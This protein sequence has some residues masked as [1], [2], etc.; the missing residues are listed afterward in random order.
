MTP[1]I[2]NI[3]VLVVLT[4]T[5]HAYDERCDDSPSDGRP[6]AVLGGVES[7]ALGARPFIDL[8]Q[9]VKSPHLG[10]ICTNLLCLPSPLLGLAL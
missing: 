8:S 6:D 7:R 1:L 9:A 5:A 2:P 10:D 4:S 3:L